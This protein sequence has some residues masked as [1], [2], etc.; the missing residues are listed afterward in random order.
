VYDLHADRMRVF[1]AGEDRV[2]ATRKRLEGLDNPEIARALRRCSSTTPTTRSTWCATRAAVRPDAFL[3]GQADARV[4]RVG[5]QQLRRAGSAGRAGRSRTAAAA[6]SAMQRR[7]EPNEPKFTGVV[8]KI[9]ANMD[10]SHRDR[11]AFVRVCSGRFQRGM[12]LKVQ[13]NGKEIRPNNVVTFLSQRRELLEEAYA[14]DI[15]GIPNH[16]DAAARRHADRRRDAAV[17]RTA[18]LRTG[19]VPG[20][21]DRDPLRTKQL[22]SG[23]EQLGEEGAIQVFRPLAGGTLLLGAVGNC[24]STW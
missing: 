10:P 4:L 6:A 18:V 13:R 21:R 17:H 16:G 20:C 14:G 5:H 24:S 8:F 22:R 15:I 23:L 9:Q 19:I 3:A 2:S 7:V 11:I 1:R 12:R